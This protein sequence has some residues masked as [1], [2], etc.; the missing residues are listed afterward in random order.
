MNPRL[1][2]ALT[3][4]WLDRRVDELYAWRA[5]HASKRTR[6]AML[7]RLA[8]DATCSDLIGP[9]AYAGP[10]GVDYE[11]MWFAIDGK[12]PPRRAAEIRAEIH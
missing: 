3:L 8:V 1:R 5:R 9:H 4:H 6:R 2:L 7:V 11:R 10:D 12:L